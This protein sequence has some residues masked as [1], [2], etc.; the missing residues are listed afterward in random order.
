M[1]TQGI[2]LSLTFYTK[3]ESENNQHCI[4][5][6]RFQSKDIIPKCLVYFVYQ[7]YRHHQYHL[8][9]NQKKQCLISGVLHY[10]LRKSLSC[11]QKKFDVRGKYN[12]RVWIDNVCF[13]VVCFQV[14]SHH[15]YTLLDFNRGIR[16]FFVITRL[17][18]K[19][20]PCILPRNSSLIISMNCSLLWGT[21]GTTSRENIGI[22]TVII[23]LFEWCSP[24]AHATLVLFLM[25]FSWYLSNTTNTL[26]G[27]IILV[28][29]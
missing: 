9:K 25:L 17:F 14:W 26:L 7:R 28:S 11:T 6:H 24:V 29:I 2:I 1:S 27:T 13:F 23:C 19:W 12:N 8:K 4:Q 10:C 16:F 21:L 3:K 15:S 22:V 5:P 20:S 18:G